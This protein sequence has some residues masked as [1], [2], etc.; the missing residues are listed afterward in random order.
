MDSRVGTCG[1]MGRRRFFSIICLADVA[2]GHPISVFGDRPL[3][4]FCERDSAM[5]VATPDKPS[6]TR[7]FVPVIT[8]NTL[9]LTLYESILCT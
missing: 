4:L 6:R 5:L 2:Y 7:V 3:S 9:A 1:R 8:Y